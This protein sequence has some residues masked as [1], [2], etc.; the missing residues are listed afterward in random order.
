[1][2]KLSLTLEQAKAIEQAINIIRTD[3]MHDGF[4][5]ICPLWEAFDDQ[6]CLDDLVEAREAIKEALK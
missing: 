2:V 5:D 6:M 3:L 4:G 1:M